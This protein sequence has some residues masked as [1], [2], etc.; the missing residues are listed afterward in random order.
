MHIYSKLSLFS[1]DLHTPVELYLALRHH[2]RKTC[3]L[4][5]NDYHSRKNSKSFIGCDPIVEI[6]LE[7]SLLVIKTKHQV[8]KKSID[9]CISVAKQVQELLDDFSFSEQ[10]FNGFFGRIGFEFTLKDETH[11]E[12]LSTD[13]DIPDL[14][15]FIFKYII[16]ID[17]F[18]SDGYLLENDFSQIK[19]ST[20]IN[21]L[22]QKNKTVQLP[23]ET[24]G[25]EDPDFSDSE[26]STLVEKGIKHCQRGDVFQLVLS[27]E[28]RQHF[29]GDD[30]QVY[31]ELRRLNPSPYLYYYDFEQYRLF[32]SSP[33][34]Q[35][36]VRSG[37]AI[38]HP[39]A[40]T[41]PHTGNK[42]EDQLN[43]EFLLKDEKE[44]SEHTMLVDLTRNDLSRDCSD[45][46][47]DKYK[48]L[49]HFSHVTHLASKVS[50]V[51]KSN[52]TF[53]ALSHSFPAGTISGTPKPKALELIQKYEL[54]NRNFYGGAI[55]QLA[56]NG[57]VNMAIVIRSIMS[58]NN[59]L[60]LRA[61]A[62]IVLDSIPEKETQ[63]IHLKLQALRSAIERS[64]LFSKTRNVE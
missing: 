4:E 57:D 17:N 42:E 38:I 61:G 7:N 1:A 52:Q 10:R 2:H 46:I 23:F 54:G 28:F 6:T 56:A 49:Q 34:A 8:I 25:S 29:F 21:H 11:I 12:K 32:G 50:G 44:N 19:G 47:V 15:L 51:L 48:E 18:T 3:L 53:E 36:I 62:G 9:S 55:G 40:C 30:F 41:V 33:E 37:K 22:F 5:S 24:I 39:F 60:H 13:S 58:K 27:N 64:H 26:F 16:V 43:I 35:L 63:E 31:R 20:T 14:H 45:V 59:V